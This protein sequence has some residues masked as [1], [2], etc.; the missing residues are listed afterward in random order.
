MDG[1]DCAVLKLIAMLLLRLNTA[2]L[3]TALKDDRAVLK[4]N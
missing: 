2:L 1:F 4:L 3:P